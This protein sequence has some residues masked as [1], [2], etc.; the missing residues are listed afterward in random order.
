L[1]PAGLPLEFEE[2]FG[3]IAGDRAG[4]ALAALGSPRR[5]HA[6]VNTLKAN[7]DGLL[8]ELSALEPEPVTWCPEG[9]RF[10]ENRRD[11]LVNHPAALDGRLY[12]QS[13]SSWLPVIALDPAP[14]QEILDLAAA[15]G[16]KAL[17]LA[18]RMENRGRLA[19]VEPIR[20]RFFRLQG[21]L[22]RAGVTIA[23]TYLKDGRS[24]GGAV[25]GRFDR[26]L[27]DAPCSSEAKLRPNDAE[28]GRHWSL[29]KVHEAAH[30]QRGL[31]VSAFDALKPGGVL[32]YAT[33]SSAPEEDEGVLAHLLIER[34]TAAIRPFDLPPGVPGLGGI[35]AW[36]GQTW[37]AEVAHARRILPD[38]DFDVFFV[39]R[40]HKPAP[41]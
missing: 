4:P 26:V 15:P 6:R 38:Q 39:A 32:V 33:C 36:D 7:L 19:C 18:A 21:N 1:G 35:T 5:P 9:L 16:G 3:A 13:P 10:P 30:K 12:P 41:A 17:H 22:R 28:S 20:E 11:D 34:P 14:D 2:R 37:P 31:I 27:L 24:V 25:P 23:A 29:R 40:V 8:S